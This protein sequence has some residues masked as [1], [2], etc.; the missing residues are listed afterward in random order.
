MTKHSFSFLASSFLIAAL[1][2]HATFLDTMLVHPQERARQRRT[3]VSR[4]A[5]TVDEICD[6]ILSVNFA[7]DIF[8][9][10]DCG[11][12][13]TSG[14]I[15]VTCDGICQSCLD[16]LC[17]VHSILSRFAMVDGFGWFPLSYRYQAALTGVDGSSN[18]LVLEQTFDSGDILAASGC[19]T[20]INNQ[21][22]DSCTFEDD[23]E[24]GVRHD[25][26]NI[27]GVDSLV[28][29]ADDIPPGSVILPLGPSILSLQ[30]C[31]LA[32]D[33]IPPKKDIPDDPSKDASKLF[34][35]FDANRGGLDRKARARG[36]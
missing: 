3:K 4:N 21:Q 1:G 12:G 28:C 31:L 17:V 19:A 23:C 14:E 36:R 33:E 32:D 6:D 13:S 25:C 27:E 24:G 29:R 11:E 5:Q 22:C 16:D 18:V 7:E 8:S 35:A 10:C 2:A 20:F 30:G 9:T 15:E 34:N 26:R